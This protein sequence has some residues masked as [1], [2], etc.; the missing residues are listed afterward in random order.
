MI[1]VLGSTG[2]LGST[3][4]QLLRERQLDFVGASRS[5]GVD[6]R[7]EEETNALFE[8]VK[9]TVVFNCA[10][11]VGGIQFG[12]Q[13]TAEIFANNLKMTLNTYAA[14]DRYGIPKIINPITNCTYPGAASYFKVDE[15][16]DG[17]LHESVRTYG[18]VKKA[19][20]IASQAYRSQSTLVAN[21]IVLPN[22]Y[23][24][25]DHL[26]LYRAHALGALISKFVR[27]KKSGETSVVVW[28]TG[29]PIREWLH[30]RDGAESLVRSLDLVVGADPI[31]VGR[32]H[33]IS[34]R[35]LAF[36]IREAV[37]VD[38]EIVFDETKPD[39][40]PMKTIDGSTG[41][42]ALRWKP[43]IELEAGLRETVEWYEANL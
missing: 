23:G 27:A 40:A 17:P 18:F 20:W 14:I 29:S 10:S 33:G 11:Y 41:E 1:L 35:D 26:D 6:L 15:W 42:R 4:C 21:H 7:N 3:L 8:R 32:G 38:C 16:W 5:T 2:F 31:N 9:P 13:H 36:K 22:M 12:L 25:G 24:P 30:I 43:E 39:G 28:G 34:V 37:S 19:I